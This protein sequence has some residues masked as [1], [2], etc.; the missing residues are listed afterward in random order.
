MSSSTLFADLHLASGHSTRTSICFRK[1]QSPNQQTD[2]PDGIHRFFKVSDGVSL[3][4]SGFHPLFTDEHVEAYANDKKVTEKILQLLNG[5]S[6]SHIPL[7]K[8]SETSDYPYHNESFALCGKTA[9]VGTR[10]VETTKS[11][12]D[13]SFH[14]SN[15]GTKARRYNF[16]S[17]QNL[18]LSCTP[19][20]LEEALV[21]G[22]ADFDTVEILSA[23]IASM[24]MLRR[25]SVEGKSNHLNISLDIPNFHYYPSVFGKVDQGLC[26]P[27]EA[28]QWMDAV[29]RRH[30]QMGA[31]LEK[32]IHRE[33]HK[34]TANATHK[35]S[36]LVTQSDNAVAT[37]IR[38]SLISGKIPTLSELLQQLSSQSDGRWREFYGLLKRSERPK[39][40]RSLGYL[41]YVFEVI[42]KALVKRP[43]MPS[44]SRCESRR[45]LISIDDIAEFRIYTKAQKYLK[46]IGDTTMV[47]PTLL[48]I[49]PCQRMFVNGNQRAHFY[50]DD[51]SPRFPVLV[52]DSPG[53]LDVQPLLSPADVVE[54]LHGK[55][56]A[57]NLKGLFKEVGL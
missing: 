55:E 48:E 49:Y 56:C 24:V 12:Q 25:Q 6:I 14:F 19:P 11:Y 1:L 7:P 57:E 32:A 38:Q 2:S 54:R 21:H 33:I 16:V 9:F 36:I 34:R 47:K 41:F 28:L 4:I 20:Q 18:H 8:Y 27:E 46:R 31:V 5:V 50:V 40:F 13:L 45:L 35:Y 3:S 53:N 17:N 51:P 43:S 26:T 23:N 10:G 30:D 52:E 39:D 29:D 15:E 37:F 42:K 44:E 22:I